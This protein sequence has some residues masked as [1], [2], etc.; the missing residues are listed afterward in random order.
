[1]RCDRR[2]REPELS[3]TLGSLLLV[4]IVLWKVKV[5]N[6]GWLRAINNIERCAE[7][8]CSPNP[9]PRLTLLC[10]VLFGSSASMRT[11]PTEQLK[12]ALHI[13]LWDQLRALRSIRLLTSELSSSPSLMPGL[14]R[15]N[16]NYNYNYNWIYNSFWVL[17]TFRNKIN[18]KQNY[19][20]D[21]R[22]EDISGY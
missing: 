21:F 9:T 1:M 10:A 22:W 13:K 20:L 7:G 6:K 8:R 15:I 11:A 2:K 4:Y 12:I 19:C 14:A 5:T 16:S 17:S 3:P 18:L